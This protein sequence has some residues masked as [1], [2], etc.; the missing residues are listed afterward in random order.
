MW[1][2]VTCCGTRNHHGARP[3][4]R[5]ALAHGR[6]AVRRG[7]RAESC[8]DAC[9]K[10]HLRRSAPG[11]W[12]AAHGWRAVRRRRR[13]SARLHACSASR[14]QADASTSGSARHILVRVLEDGAGERLRETGD[15]LLGGAGVRLEA[16]RYRPLSGSRSWGPQGRGELGHV[17]ERGQ[18]GSSWTLGRRS[19]RGSA[20]GSGRLLVVQRRRLFSVRQLL[21][22]RHTH[23]LVCS[24]WLPTSGRQIRGRLARRLLALQ[25]HDR[26][27]LAR[28]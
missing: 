8:L 13:G 1:M 17:R 7:S 26:G 2:S 18:I 20:A 19:R 23:G 11:A 25:T 3:S 15:L 6:R 4:I 21:D 9:G 10:P 28:G 24:W 12:N 16:P 22:V 27:W 5:S 14:G